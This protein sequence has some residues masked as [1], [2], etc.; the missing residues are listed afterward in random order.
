MKSA[1]IRFICVYPREEISGEELHQ[2]R[3]DQLRHSERTQAR[4]V[5]GG[6]DR[7]R[8]PTGG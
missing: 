2:R 5:A 4:D 6:D 3:P 1:K 8:R 7:A